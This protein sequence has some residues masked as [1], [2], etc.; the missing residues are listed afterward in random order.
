MTKSQ[1]IVFL[2][3]LGLFREVRYNGKRGQFYATLA[4][5]DV[6]AAAFTY[7]SRR[8]MIGS[9]GSVGF[10]P[11]RF[12]VDIYD[13]P[14]NV[15]TYDKHGECHLGCVQFIG[16]TILSTPN[17]GAFRRSEDIQWTYFDTKIG[18][19]EPT[20]LTFRQA[21]EERGWGQG[22]NAWLKEPINCGQHNRKAYSEE[23]E[24]PLALHR[25][26]PTVW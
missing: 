15:G 2:M 25:N 7:F 22:F 8:G 10:K 14:L 23:R 13:S 20:P 9:Q 3:G 1:I 11:S 4:K 19:A 17:A 6:R 24:S 16:E 21:R 26:L 5:R 12:Q 18:S